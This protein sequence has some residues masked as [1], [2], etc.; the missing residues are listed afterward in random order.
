MNE[1]SFILSLLRHCLFWAAWQA[2]R[3]TP[4]VGSFLSVLLGCS[5]HGH[6]ACLH[7]HSP[8]P[9][10]HVYVP[11]PTVCLYV[12][13]GACMRSLKIW[14]K[15]PAGKP[16]LKKMGQLVNACVTTGC[17]PPQN[18]SRIMRTGCSIPGPRPEV[19]SGA[20]ITSWPCSECAR[21]VPDA[22]VA[23]SALNCIDSLIELY[24]P[25]F[26]AA[27]AGYRL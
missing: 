13:L 16:N 3:P 15:K 17:S 10:R 1:P 2:R 4:Q 22:W 25:P 7:E 20:M 8:T 11:P 26:V 5:L 27:A 24:N 6:S 23:P 19:H 9:Q 14:T 18:R 21:N 12:L